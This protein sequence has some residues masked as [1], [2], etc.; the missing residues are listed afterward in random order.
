MICMGNQK[1]GCAKTTTSLNVCYSLA[2]TYGMKTL[3]IDMDSQGSSSLCLGIDVSRDETNTIDELIDILIEDPKQKIPWE[4]IQEYIYTPT[5]EDRQ[6]DSDN[7]MKWVKVNVPFG[8]D[9][10]PASLNLSLTEMNMGIVGGSKY[11][12]IYQ[13]YLKDIVA[14][15]EENSDYDYIVIDTPPSLGPLSVNSMC[16]ARDGI[17][18]CSN[19][20]VISL[21]GCFRFI[22]SVETIKKMNDNHRGMLGIL[23]TLYSERRVVD[24]SIDDWVEEF[25]PIPTFNTRIPETSDVKKANSSMLLVSQINKKAKAAFDSLTAEIIDACNH[26]EKKIG[27]AA[28]EQAEEGA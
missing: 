26:P 22:G 11:G 12:H 23:L 15:I 28:A 3:L 18:L 16:A 13:N 25:L 4:E 10:M 8:F 5:F 21:R 2:N 24:R 27:S 14:V 9:C 19:T 1:G 17:V 7:G 20:D 6:R